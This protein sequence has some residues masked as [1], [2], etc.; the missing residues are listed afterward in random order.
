M[1]P[2]ELDPNAIAQLRSL[3]EN[4]SGIF[5]QLVEAFTADTERLLG[6][7]TTAATAANFEKTRHIAHTIKGS[8][9]NFGAQYMRELCI[10]IEDACKRENSAP[11]ANSVER[12]A[13]EY[14]RVRDTL[15]SMTAG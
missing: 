8:S 6:E 11:L 7:L 4:G 12:L 9:G 10:E 15:R 5:N 3:D 2:A 14:K 13:A 1:T